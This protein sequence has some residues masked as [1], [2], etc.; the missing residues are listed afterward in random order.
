[1]LAAYFTISEDNVRLGLRQPWVSICSD[2]PAF[3]AEPPWTE[4]S[5]HP[6]TYGSFAR[7]VG[8][9]ARDVGLFDLTEAVRRM[10]SLPAETLRLR[11]RG[12]LRPGAF[13]DIVVFDPDAVLDTAS[14]DAPHSYATGVRHV[15]VN[16]IPVVRDGE[17]AGP[18][19]GRRL[20][21]GS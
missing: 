21:R 15:V 10:T 6:R 13:A 9:Y 17:V 8:H 1:M 3:V 2:A 18:L 7:V 20:R 16:G 4:V 14:Y 11:D 5:A 19:P 12:V